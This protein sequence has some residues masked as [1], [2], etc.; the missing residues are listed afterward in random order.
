MLKTVVF[1]VRV[2]RHEVSNAYPSP[3]LIQPHQ[4]E[5]PKALSKEFARFKSEV[6]SGHYLFDAG[7]RIRS[8]SG[9]TKRRGPFSTHVFRP[10]LLHRRGLCQAHCS[11]K[12]GGSCAILQCLYCSWRRCPPG[13]DVRNTR[14]EKRADAC[15]ARSFLVFTLALILLMYH[16][17]ARVGTKDVGLESEI[18]AT[19]ELEGVKL[20]ESDPAFVIATATLPEPGPLTE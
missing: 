3:A 17:F 4:T 20:I 8:P 14:R 19:Q 15:L 5:K 13:N 16:S 1:V 6:S 18:A 10:P 11:N 2:C 12:Q 7:R 9:P